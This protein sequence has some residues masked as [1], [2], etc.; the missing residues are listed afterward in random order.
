MSIAQALRQ[1][2]DRRLILPA[3]QREYVWKPRQVIQLF[4]SVMRGYPVGSFLSWKV[5][6]ETVSKFKFYGFMKDYSAFANYHNPEIDIPS[7]REIV[8]ILDG[9]Q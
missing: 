8:A 6:P 1:I 5:L 7:D 9:Q 3:I 4:D 2:Q